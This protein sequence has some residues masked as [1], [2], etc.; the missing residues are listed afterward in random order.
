MGEEALKVA[1]GWKGLRIGGA[2]TWQAALLFLFSILPVLVV[3]LAR[4]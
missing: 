3:R 1:Q 4:L 2:L